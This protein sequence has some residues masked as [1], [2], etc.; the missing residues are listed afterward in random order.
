VRE[1]RDD[2]GG[3]WPMV[4]DP[5]GRTALGFGVAGV[6]ES[7]LVDPDGRIVAKVLGG[8]RATDFERLLARARTGRS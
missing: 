4:D 2:K 6:P 1:F 5:R 3:D 8:I 7:Y